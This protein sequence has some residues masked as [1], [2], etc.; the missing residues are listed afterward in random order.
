MLFNSI[1]VCL[2][3]AFTVYI[4]SKQP[5][6][7]IIINW[8][9]VSSVFRVFILVLKHTNAGHGVEHPTAVS[10]LNKEWS[11]RQWP[12]TGANRI[13]K[14]NPK[15]VVKNRQKISGS[16]GYQQKLWTKKK[17]KCLETQH[18]KTR[19]GKRFVMV[20]GNKTQQLV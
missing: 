3:S 4:M 20:T 7:E 19:Q 12:N 11:G 14:G 5:N 10:S 18:R 9:C 17:K 1:H 2:F 6:I 13:I 16:G 15:R 8:K